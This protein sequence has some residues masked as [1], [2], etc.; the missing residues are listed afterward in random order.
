M[1]ASF[2]LP[3]VLLRIM[4]AG[5]RAL[6][7][8]EGIGLVAAALCVFGMMF[9]TAVDVGFRYVIGHPLSWWYDLLMNYMLPAAFYLAFSYTLAHHGHLA[10]E[11]FSN[12]LPPRLGQGLLALG[13]LA[14]SAVLYVVFQGLSQESWHA[15]RNDEVIAGAILWPVWISKLI[16]AVG[17]IL[18]TLR[19]FLLGLCHALAVRYPNVFAALGLRERTSELD[20]VMP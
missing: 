1:N 12:R 3:G 15:W 14:S 17:I 19:T 9:V 4:R 11:Y 7:V 16:L 13:M 10:V 5:H 18:L 8:A 2:P 20:E 6:S